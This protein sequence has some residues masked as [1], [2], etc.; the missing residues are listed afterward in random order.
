MC[1]GSAVSTDVVFDP[2][3]T[4]ETFD[5]DDDDGVDDGD[6]D[7]DDDGDDDDDYVETGVV[8]TSKCT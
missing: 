4:A 8:L 6:D 3:C 2:P 5:D 7:D 1:S